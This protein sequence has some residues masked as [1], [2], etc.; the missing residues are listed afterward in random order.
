[1]PL[2]RS[3]AARDQQRDPSI[4]RQ[5]TLGLV[6]LLLV[7]VAI[8]SVVW[9]ARVQFARDFALYD[10]ELAGQVQGLS[11]GGA[12]Y[13]NGVR[14]GE[15]MSLALNR[16]DPSK[17]V[18]RIQVSADTPVRQDTTA[19]LEWLGVSGTRIIQLSG[20]SLSK[21]LL[22]QVGPANRIPVI[23]AARAAFDASNPEG[24]SAAAQALEALDLLNERLSDKNLAA[25][26]AGLVNAHNTVGTWRGNA[27]NLAA[28]DAQLRMTTEA[29]GKLAQTAESLNGT[30]NGDLR[31]QLQ[32]LAETSAQ[33]KTSIRNAR[34]QIAQGQ[35]AVEGRLQAL[36]ALGSQIEGVAGMVA[37]AGDV[38]EKFDA[39]QPQLLGAPANRELKV[40]P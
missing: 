34:T 2:D 25:I 21:P 27:K 6:C 7:A 10:V 26:D 9:L 23:H 20:G 16:S 17:V 29:T 13:I 4:D 37:K 12:V 19:A 40:A 31:R 11:K 1:M 14:S 18:A 28:I 8:V 35:V 5:A 33:T 39:P 22:R 3:A 15:V 36:P 24:K 32:Q 30:V 38:V